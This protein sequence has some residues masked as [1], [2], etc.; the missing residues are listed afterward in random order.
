MTRMQ[1]GNKGTFQYILT[2]LMVLSKKFFL[3]RYNIWHFKSK[4]SNSLRKGLLLLFK[5]QKGIKANCSKA[6]KKKE[7]AQKSRA[8]S[9]F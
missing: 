8:T 2:S 5:K 1:M 9:H 3:R 7:K 6:H 4:A